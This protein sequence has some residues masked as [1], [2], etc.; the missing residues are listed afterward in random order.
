MGRQAEAR[1]RLE[2]VSRMSRYRYVPPVFPAILNVALDDR[3][4]AFAWLEKAYTDRSECMT[5]SQSFG[6][7]VDPYWDPLRNDPRFV[8]L[9][10][11]VGL[12]ERLA[13]SPPRAQP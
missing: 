6:L 2:E 3:D 8:D 11:R 13:W 9:L 10:R 7:G 5:F 12:A 1:E 4:A